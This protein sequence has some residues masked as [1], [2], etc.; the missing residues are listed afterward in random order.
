MGLPWLWLKVG[1]WL[2]AGGEGHK[3]PECTMSEI[4]I[5]TVFEW[6]RRE[7]EL[8]VDSPS[9][10]M[11]LPCPKETPP[12][13]TPP[14][15]E[16]SEWMNSWLTKWVHKAGRR[17]GGFAEGGWFLSGAGLGVAGSWLLLRTSLAYVRWQLMDASWDAPL[18]PLALLA[19]SL[20]NVN[21]SSPHLIHFEWE[22][23]GRPMKTY[24]ASIG[25]L[26]RG[27]T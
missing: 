15:L 4:Q 22:L 14:A 1:R 18:A 26:A 24:E 10:S 13:Y 7:V 16:Q 23:R 3:M 11:T 12:K 17:V 25:S 2:V 9:L 5:Q 27:R 21:L 19:V 6:M 20:S 8:G